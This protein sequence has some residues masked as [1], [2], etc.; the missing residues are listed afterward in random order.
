M[1]LN[2]TPLGAATASFAPHVDFAVGGAA[3]GIA[4][5]D[6]NGDGKP[7]LVI[8][9][10]GIDAISILVNT[11]ATGSATPTF[12]A[13]ETFGVDAGS[14]EVVV[15]D[16]NGD[17]KPDVATIDFGSTDFVSVL[18][19]TTSPGTAFVTLEG[20]QEYS[21]PAYASTL[22]SGDFNGDGRADIVSV[23]AWRRNELSFLMNSPGFIAV[24][25]GDRQYRLDHRARP[26][27]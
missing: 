24:G 16:F 4:F 22:A 13:P 10:R 27:Q 8:G 3:D 23:A 14:R 12:A 9:D 5:G 1:L 20:P 6:L 2:T 21:A 15:G 7:D 11:T 18:L 19:N 25:H 26:A 17:G